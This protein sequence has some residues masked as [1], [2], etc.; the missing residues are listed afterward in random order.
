M[1]VIKYISEKAIKYIGYFSL[2]LSKFFSMFCVM[3]FLSL[4]VYSPILFLLKDDEVEVVSLVQF[5]SYCILGPIIIETIVFFLLF[6]MISRYLNK[7]IVLVICALLISLIQNDV[8]CLLYMLFSLPLCLIFQKTRSLVYVMFL[9]VLI[10]C[11]LFIITLTPM[12]SWVEYMDTNI[13]LLFLFINT[14]ISYV[15]FGVLFSAIHLE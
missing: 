15:I 11:S 10:N 12:A 9:H 6:R 7:Y 8:F 3:L 1:S 2:N 14:I 5:L 4:F 13:I